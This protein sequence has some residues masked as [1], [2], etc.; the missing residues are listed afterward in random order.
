MKDFDVCMGCGDVPTNDLEDCVISI[1]GSTVETIQEMIDKGYTQD[2]CGHWYNPS[3][4]IDSY[5]ANW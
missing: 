2:S 4:Y 1:F 5:Y 3:D